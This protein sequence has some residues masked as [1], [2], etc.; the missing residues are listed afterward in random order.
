MLADGLA[1]GVALGLALGVAE[2]DAL[3][4]VTALHQNGSLVPL[5]FIYISLGLLGV[6]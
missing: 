5:R 2:A 4:V 1:D 6:P 3:G